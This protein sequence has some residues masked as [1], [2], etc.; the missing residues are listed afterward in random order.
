MVRKDDHQNI[1][2]GLG[3]SWE[4]SNNRKEIICYL[5]Q[6][7]YD[8]EEVAQSLRRLLAKKQTS[9]SNLSAQIKTADNIVVLDDTTLK[10]ETES[11]AG[12]ILDP[13]VMADTVII[14]D[15]LWVNLPG[16]SELQ[17]DWKRNRGPYIQ[18]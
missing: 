17:I 3:S 11:D 14:L 4:I 2:G 12:A 15:K 8:A 18:I 13:L 5:R 6:G 10:I 7:L 1:V 9:H 16:F